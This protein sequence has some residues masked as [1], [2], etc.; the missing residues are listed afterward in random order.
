MIIHFELTKYWAEFWC[1]TVAMV[2][3]YRAGYIW[4]KFEYS[5]VKYFGY[6]IVNVIISIALTIIGAH[7]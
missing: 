2:C 7:L 3:A 4:V 6:F 5:G 1:H